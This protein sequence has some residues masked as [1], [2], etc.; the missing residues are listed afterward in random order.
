MGTAAKTVL[1]G[2]MR[3]VA[4]D[5]A[6]M[7]AKTP[8]D[9]GAVLM[10]GVVP[11]ARVGDYLD[12]EASPAPDNVVIHR[13]SDEW[14]AF[15]RRNM[16]GKRDV[17]INTPGGPVTGGFT[18][19]DGTIHIGASGCRLLP[20]LAV[21]G[22]DAETALRARIKEQDA[23]LL[24]HATNHDATRVKLVRAESDLRMANATI[25][26]LHKDGLNL[27]A[28]NVQ[29]RDA[30]QEATTTI[31]ELRNQLNRRPPRK[32]KARKKVRRGGK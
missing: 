27:D 16:P 8:G 10:V 21:G 20:P 2:R 23:H 4:I 24:L 22:Q 9:E 30:L 28:R 32:P 26:R 14:A 7:T 15:W 29:L 6:K 5:G 17:I 11:G 19:D 13:N 31:Q 25:S 12:I 1:P 18:A 3:I